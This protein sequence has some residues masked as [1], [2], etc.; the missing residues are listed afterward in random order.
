LYIQVA[1]ELGIFGIVTFAGFVGV[2]LYYQRKYRRYIINKFKRRTWLWGLL[3]A[4][5][6]AIVTLMV[7]GMFGHNL[8]RSNWYYY[9]AVTIAV[10]FILARLNKADSEEMACVS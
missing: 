10:G 2:M 8:Y 9:G 6:I 7:V 3:M 1:A 4:M 5:T